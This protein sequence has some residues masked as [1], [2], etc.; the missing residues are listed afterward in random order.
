MGSIRPLFFGALVALAGLVM[1][2]PALRQEGPLL[3]QTA[4]DGTWDV[5]ALPVY[6]CEGFHSPFDV[7]LTL[8][9]HTSKPIPLEAR[10]FDS[11]TLALVGDD[12]VTVAPVAVVVLADR[13]IANTADSSEAGELQRGR[14]NQFTFGGFCPGFPACSDPKSGNWSLDPST[15]PY[16]KPGTYGVF[17]QSGDSSQYLISPPC[18]GTFVRQ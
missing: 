12:T 11:T 5:T 15:H 18:A 6:I 9:P 7:R 2:A 16:L 1:A 17:M 3:S 14:T 13:A 8:G 10:L 4:F